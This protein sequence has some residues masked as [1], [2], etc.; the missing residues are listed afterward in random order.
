MISFQFSIV[1]LE[2]SPYGFAMLVLNSIPH[3]HTLRIRLGAID[4]QPLASELAGVPTVRSRMAGAIRQ[5][6]ERL[7]GTMSQVNLR[8]GTG[9]IIEAEVIVATPL[10]QIAV[11][12]A[13]GDAIALALAHKLPISGDTTLLP[14]MQAVVQEQA[15]EVVL[16]SGIETFLSSL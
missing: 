10:E 3:T 5:F 15:D 2:P 11:P 12:V 9:N 16:P 7:D 6:V 4:A 1:G 13:C 8:R 14:L